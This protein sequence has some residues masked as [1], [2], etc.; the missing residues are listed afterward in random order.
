MP[1]EQEQVNTW[2]DSLDLTGRVNCFLLR[3]TIERMLNRLSEAGAVKQTEEVLRWA[4]ASNTRAH[5]VLMLKAIEKEPELPG[6][7]TAVVWEKIKD[8]DVKGVGEALQMLVKLT[9]N[10]IRERAEGFFSGEEIPIL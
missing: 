9:K 5:Q 4:V 7:M 10:G 1:I 6:D 3:Q 8:R 2:M